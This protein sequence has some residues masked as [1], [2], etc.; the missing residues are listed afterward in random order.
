M[1]IISLI[2]QLGMWGERFVIVVPSLSRDFLPS[3]WGMYYPTRWDWAV[4]AGTVGF[5][6]LCFFLFVRILPVISMAEMRE[7]VHSTGG[8]EHPADSFHPTYVK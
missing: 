5:F 7:L 6:L 4:L 8:G 3:S 1:F 2:I